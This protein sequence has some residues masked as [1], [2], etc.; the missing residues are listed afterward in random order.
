M[1]YGE[2]GAYPMSVYV[3][4]R[5]VDYWSKLINGI[6]SKLSLILYKYMYI[7]KFHGQY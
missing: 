2:F 7:K 3:K 6:D 1:I 4:L 5:M